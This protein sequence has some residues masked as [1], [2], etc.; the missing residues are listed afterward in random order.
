MPTP[1]PQPPAATGAPKPQGDT[2]PPASAEPAQQDPAPVVEPVTPVTPVENE[3]EP[4][5]DGKNPA[6][7]E[8]AKYRRQ[9]RETETQVTA[10]E[11]RVDALTRATVETAAAKV[12]KDGASI[13]GAGA[14]PDQFVGEDGR[15]DAVAVEAAANALAGQFSPKP[16]PGYVPAQG[17]GAAGTKGDAADFELAFKPPR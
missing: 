17:T 12:L 4:E 5:D 6:N 9:L 16:K 1:K 15:V 13:W 11:A 14:T 3:Q 7:R 10:L 8:A 2:Q